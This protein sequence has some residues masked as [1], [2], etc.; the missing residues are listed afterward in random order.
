MNV[1]KY[2][3]I[4][5]KKKNLIFFWEH[6]PKMAK[7]K[8]KEADKDKN[9]QNLNEILAKAAAKKQVIPRIIDK[10]L[11]IFL[12]KEKEGRNLSIFFFQDL[13]DKRGGK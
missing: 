2:I 6:P 10:K 12:A 9:K 4:N 13:K 3:N 11:R 5:K 7:D 8:K 1:T